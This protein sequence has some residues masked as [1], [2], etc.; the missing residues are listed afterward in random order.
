MLKNFFVCFIDKKKAANSLKASDQVVLFKT[1]HI[2]TDFASSFKYK[3]TYYISSGLWAAPINH[4]VNH[5]SKHMP[6]VHISHPYTIYSILD[7]AD[8]TIL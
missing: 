7:A 4:D 1:V 5:V 3:Y 6:S 2:V 8:I